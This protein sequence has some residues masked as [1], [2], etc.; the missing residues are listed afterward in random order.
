MGSY[1]FQCKMRLVLVVLKLL[2][3]FK[4]ETTINT[5]VLFDVVLLES[6]PDQGLL[7]CINCVTQLA[8]EFF[9][10][11][12]NFHMRREIFGGIIFSLANGAL[13]TRLIGVVREF[14]IAQFCCR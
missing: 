13:E 3:Q 7:A 14:M 11:L 2:V 6:V 9:T 8:F 10:A 4:L 5:L 1:I 12:M